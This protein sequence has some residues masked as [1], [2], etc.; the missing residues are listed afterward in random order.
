MKKLLSLVG[1]GML[2]TSA[3]APLVANT[4]YEPKTEEV[5]SSEDKVETTKDLI[6]VQEETISDHGKEIKKKDLTDEELHKIIDIALKEKTHEK[7]ALKLINELKQ[8]ND[9]GQNEYIVHNM[10]SSTW[11]ISNDVCKVIDWL[12][13]I[14]DYA[15]LDGYL[16]DVLIVLLPIP[17]ANKI[18]KFIFNLIKDHWSENN[19]LSYN[20]GNGI[21]IDFNCILYVPKSIE[22]IWT[23]NI[24]NG[25]EETN[26][27][28]ILI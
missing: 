24:I 12:V 15:T 10:S 14:A 26:T 22:K 27:K 4:T 21:G 18:I 20:K 17:F 25:I 5:I 2:A 11:K 16:I 7:Q 8:Y 28:K 6:S 13:K 1:T 19:P 23:Q 9:Y 3:V